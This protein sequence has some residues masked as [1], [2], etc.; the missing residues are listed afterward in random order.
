MNLSL[1]IARQGGGKGEE[2]TPVDQLLLHPAEKGREGGVRK[3]RE[4]LRQGELLEVG[5]GLAERLQVEPVE[6]GGDVLGGGPRS[7]GPGGA[8][9]ELVVR[10][11]LD[12]TH[13]LHRGDLGGRLAPRG[14]GNGEREPCH[15]GE[16]GRRCPSP[17]IPIGCRGHRVFLLA[18]RRGMTGL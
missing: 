18:A 16:N 4:A 7:G 2:V 10:E 3:G 12:V 13:Q 1:R 8:T 5:P 11:E 15:P 17:G 9:R 6:L 14:G